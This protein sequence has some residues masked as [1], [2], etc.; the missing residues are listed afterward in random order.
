M[1]K[2]L[3]RKQLKQRRRSDGNITYGDF[4]RAAMQSSHGV[5]MVADVM[6]EKGFLIE[7][8]EP[9]GGG[10]F[11][12]VYKG[13]WHRTGG[14]EPQVPP[15]VV[16]VKVIRARQS[17]SSD[18]GKA[19]E[20]LARE[21]H[22]S[23]NHIHPNLLHVL[24][25][26]IE[27][28]PYLM[29]FEYCSGGSLH[30]IL[31]G[32]RRFLSRDSDSEKAKSPTRNE[33]HQRG[34][35]ITWQQRTKIALDVATGM[36]HL[37]AKGVIHRDLKPP[38]ILLLSP[39]ESSLEEPL[40][41]VADFGIARVLRKSE[42]FEEVGK[43][44]RN[45]GSWQYMAPEVF[46]CSSTQ[47]DSY[48]DKVDVYSYSIVLY[49]LMSE[50]YPFESMGFGDRLGLFVGTGGRPSEDDLPSDAPALLCDLMRRSWAGDPSSRP[51]FHRIAS[52]IQA[53]Y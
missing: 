24:E 43:L 53:A 48:D 51:P 38:N 6:K 36:A 31:H 10:T 8:L 32:T 49:E 33:Q 50:R 19:P 42:E 37:H 30:E 15:M 45:V 5:D 27:T 2:W 39:I 12:R 11:A 34:T 41:K 18:P 1:Q 4:A 16:A 13:T 21:L 26:S 44:T 22:A 14:L 52:E 7:N 46:A 9:L 40:A 20:W 3:E 23:S 35:T 29:L 17:S 47:F 25:S 28:K